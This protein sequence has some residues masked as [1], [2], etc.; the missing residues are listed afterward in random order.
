[1]FLRPPKSDKKPGFK[2][3][4][5]PKNKFDPKSNKKMDQFIIRKSD[6]GQTPKSTVENT[7]IAI[8]TV[9]NSTSVHSDTVQ[10]T[11]QYSV[12]SECPEMQQVDLPDTDLA[13]MT[14]DTVVGAQA[15]L[16]NLDGSRDCLAPMLSTNHKLST[17]TAQLGKPVALASAETITDNIT[18]TVQDQL[19]QNPDPYSSRICKY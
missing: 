2:K 4:R 9:Q 13:D 17:I 10:N 15:C 12:A 6:T 1:M 18:F 7:S 14:L 16:E 11:E 19:S 5:T 3:S 8:I